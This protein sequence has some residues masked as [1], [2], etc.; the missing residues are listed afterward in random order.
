M[1]AE[2]PFELTLFRGENRSYLFQMNPN[3]VG[4]ISG[5]TIQFTV[6]KKLG[7][8]PIAIT[9]STDSV[10][11]ESSKGSISIID[12]PGGTA[13]ITL[14]SAATA[15]LTLDSVDDKG[16]PILDELGFQVGVYQADVQFVDTGHEAVPSRG[17][18]TL[19]RPARD[20]P[21]P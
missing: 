17:T 14:L 9:L 21:T 2:P 7:V 6:R 18:L 5:R 10:V 4:G 11:N 15:P 1:A 3:P 20:I 16:N 12:G 13:R 8:L 19:R